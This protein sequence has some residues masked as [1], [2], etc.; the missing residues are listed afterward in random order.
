VTAL[1]E[2]R[3]LA[4][5]FAQP[6]A[7]VCALRGVDLALAEGELVLVRGTSGAGKST[8]LALLAGLDVPTSGSVFFRG[9]DLSAAGPERRAELRRLH[10]GFVFQDFRLVRHLSARDNARL[11]GLLLGGRAGRDAAARSDRLLARVGLDGRA[12]RR[13]ESLSRGEQQRVSLARAL[14]HRPAL[15]LADEP[16]ASLDPASRDAVWEL[17]LELQR[18]EGVAILAA[19]HDAAPATGRILVLEDGRL[20]AG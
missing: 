14:A 2:A 5:E 19:A 3:G 10:M 4:R 7:P 1:I 15:I 12:H 9:E 18:E 6:G 13:P 8:L 11:P 20:S 16:T 17:L